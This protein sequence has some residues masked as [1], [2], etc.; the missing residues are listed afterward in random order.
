MSRLHRPNPPRSGAVATA[1]GLTCKQQYVQQVEDKKT[2]PENSF[3]TCLRAGRQLAGMGIRNTS[4]PTVFL[5]LVSEYIRTEC[6]MPKKYVKINPHSAAS[7]WLKAWMASPAGGM[8]L[9][10][11]E[12][13]AGV[14]AWGHGGS[15]RCPPCRSAS[16]PRGSWAGGGSTSAHLPLH[17]ET[18]GQTVTGASATVSQPW[19]EIH[20]TVSSCWGS[21][22]TSLPPSLKRRA[23][24]PWCPTVQP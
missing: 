10:R 23:V 15:P 19:G 11:T 17:G 6:T 13:P 18:T 7:C 4:K 20:S 1:P 21:R 2:T 5:E 24:P 12:K 22:T 8:F 14:T 16:V 3:Q 9:L